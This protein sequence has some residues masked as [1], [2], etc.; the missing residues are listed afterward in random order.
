MRSRICSGSEKVNRDVRVRSG[1][2]RRLS[3][4]F[5]GARLTKLGHCTSSSSTPWA[6]SLVRC[7]ATFLPFQ[8][9]IRPR[10][11]I[12]VENCSPRPTA[13]A[14]NVNVPL[15]RFFLP[16]LTLLSLATQ[17]TRPTA[18]NPGTVVLRLRTLCEITERARAATTEIRP[19]R[20]T[21]TKA[22]D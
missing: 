20:G 19:S 15:I 6:S 4:L 21:S 12:A 18:T 2:A 8:R 10:A 17:R 11:A 5:V 13:F 1:C 3:A 22:T 9:E 7:V 16:C 14:L